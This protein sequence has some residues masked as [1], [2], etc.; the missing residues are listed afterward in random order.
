M[1]IAYRFFT[2]L[3]YPLIIFLIFIR[4]I[5]NKEDSFRYKEKI[6][7]SCFNVKRNYSSK[8]IWF[9]AVSIGEL[10]SIT[11]IIQKLNTQVVQSDEHYPD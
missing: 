1:I 5:I 7:S 3:F 6:F 8:L 2:I 11:P 10:K 9:H 4:K